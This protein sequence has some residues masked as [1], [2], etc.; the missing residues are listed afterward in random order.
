MVSDGELELKRSLCI[1]EW[2][3]IQGMKFPALDKIIIKHV[4]GN[5]NCAELQKRIENGISFDI[6]KLAVEYSSC[7]FTRKEPPISYLMNEIWGEIFP[8]FSEGS[9]DFEVNLDQI[10]EKAYE[11][12]IP[13]S[14]L[15]GEM[16]QIRKRWVQNTLKK[17]CEIGLADKLDNEKYK[18]YY[19]KD[20]EKNRL[21]YF[22]KRLCNL[23]AEESR[24]IS[25][26]QEIQ[27]EMKRLQDFFSE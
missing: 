16:A 19:G 5:V 15:K 17:F 12:Y 24:K 11:Y 21:E 10:L 18:I 1:T 22:F 23:Q 27:G 2:G 7:K 20:I 25:K 14:G 26:P 9:E 6:Q 8:T 3:L 13:W 4:S